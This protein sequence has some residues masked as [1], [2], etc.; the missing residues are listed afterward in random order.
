LVDDLERQLNH[1]PLRYARNPSL[2]ERLQKWVHRHP[3]LMSGGAVSAAGGV[4][5]A[6]GAIF[7]QVRESKLEN[8]E[9][10]RVFSEFEKHVPEARAL[11]P[12][13]GLDPDELA[14]ESSRARQLLTDYGVLESDNWR[15]N[16]LYQA[17]EEP[18]RQTLERDMGQLLY[19]LSAS[20]T[21]QAA[22]ISGP[23]SQSGA[24]SVDSLELNARA[25]ACFPERSVPA[26]LWN[27][28]V[29]LLERAGRTDAAA[30]A[31][32]MLAGTVGSSLIDRELDAVQLVL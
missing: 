16:R 23:G 25:L 19:L 2:R 1:Q 14:Q 13:P 26:A 11:L 22:A 21:R 9:A 32:Q 8:L 29:E 4:L 7:W 18:Q 5:L 12:L 17:L 10:R 30:G 24:G 27:Q 6:V 28:R 15:S 3:R 20:A 31:R